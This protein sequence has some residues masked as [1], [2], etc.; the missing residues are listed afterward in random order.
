MKYTM[1]RGRDEIILNT[2]TGKI[3][4]NTYGMKDIIKADLHATWNAS[5]KCWESDKLAETIEEYKS[6][7]TRCYKLSAVEERTTSATTV[8]TEAA[9]ESKPAYRKAFAAKVNGL[10]PRCH[11]YCYG[12]CRLN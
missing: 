9:K 1:S 4:G 5:E 10:C 11:T 12:D 3:T 8:E 7:L 6:Y 2:E